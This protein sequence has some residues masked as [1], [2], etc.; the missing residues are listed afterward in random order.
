MYDTITYCVVDTLITMFLEVYTLRIPKILNTELYKTSMR[1]VLNWPVGKLS[2][3]ILFHELIEATCIFPQKSNKLM[4]LLN[5]QLMVEGVKVTTGL[6][7]NSVI[8]DL[9]AQGGPI[10]DSTTDGCV[11]YGIRAADTVEKYLTMMTANE[12]KLGIEGE[13]DLGNREIFDANLSK[14]KNDYSCF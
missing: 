10:N 5:C 6:P 9:P 7:E 4:K 14:I 12:Y 11:R 8:V 13:V 2:M 1:N 3:H